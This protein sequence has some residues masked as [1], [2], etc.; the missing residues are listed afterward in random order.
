M[1]V[2]KYFLNPASIAVVGAAERLDQSGGAVQRKLRISGYTRRIVPINPKRGEIDGLK[3]ALSLKAMQSPVDLVAVLVRPD[4]ILDVVM[5][6]R[7]PDT[8][9][10]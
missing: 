2:I 6:L 8:G 5:K 3:V 10:S 7:T 4:S 1:D 9:T